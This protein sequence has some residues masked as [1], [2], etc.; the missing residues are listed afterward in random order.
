MPSIALLSKEYKIVAFIDQGTSGFHVE[1]FEHTNEKELTSRLESLR[2]TQLFVSREFFDANGNS[3]LVDQPVSDDDSAYF[4]AVA[5]ALSKYY[6]IATVVDNSLKEYFLL[7]LDHSL[8]SIAR[9]E[10]VVMLVHISPEDRGQ[11]EDALTTV[12]PILTAIRENREEWKK[13]LD[14][15]TKETLENA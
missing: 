14:Q 2:G 13:A 6:F 5:N 11:L 4:E 8:D 10:L 15:K 9:R 7:T 12:K 1:V 3:Y